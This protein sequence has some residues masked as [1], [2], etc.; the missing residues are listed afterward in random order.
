MLSAASC[1]GCRFED[2]TEGQKQKQQAAAQDAAA[3]PA[4][5]G[6]SS[7]SSAPEEA[8]SEDLSADSNPAVMAGRGLR[9]M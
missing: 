6:S 1:P 8:S 3:A 5:A 4:P 7:S 9:F 2:T